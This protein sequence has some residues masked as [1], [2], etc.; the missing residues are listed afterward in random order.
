MRPKPNRSALLG[1]YLALSA[2]AGTVARYD[3]PIWYL[4]LRTWSFVAR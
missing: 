2:R 3:S 4:D 1:L